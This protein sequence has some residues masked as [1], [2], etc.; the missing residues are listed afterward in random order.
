MMCPLSPEALHSNAANLTQQR[1]VPLSSRASRR[2][3]ICC[4]MDP[5]MLKHLLQTRA[6]AL[7]AVCCAPTSGRSLNTSSSALNA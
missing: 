6:S 3:A 5:I 2:C 1:G 7:L 4:S